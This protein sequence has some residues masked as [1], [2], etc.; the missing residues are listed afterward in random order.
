MKNNQVEV[1]ISNI[2]D[3]QK[4]KSKD[5][6]SELKGAYKGELS[7]SIEYSNRKNREY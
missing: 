4:E 1:N 3:N 5:I 6:V 2:E 7:S